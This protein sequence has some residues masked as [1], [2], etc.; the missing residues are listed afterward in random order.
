MAAAGAR[1]APRDCCAIRGAPSR[2]LIIY[3]PRSCRFD[4]PMS[5]TPDIT[6]DDA[7]I[8]AAGFFI[9]A[10]PLPLIIFRCHFTPF[11]HAAS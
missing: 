8:L 1:G 2:T 9:A 4:S 5:P 6:P 3:T 7:F 11:C 10:T